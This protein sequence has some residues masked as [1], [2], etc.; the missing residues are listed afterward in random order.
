[1][2]PGPPLSWGFEEPAPWL[3]ASEEERR[4]GHLSSDLC[5]IRGEHFFVRGV[6]EIPLKDAHGLFLWNVWVSLS[7]ESFGRML[8]CFD[9]PDRAS[10]PACFGW[11]SNSIP[12]YP[13][14]L[15]LKTMVHTRA[16]GLRPAIELEPTDH[17]LA[18]E[19]RVG[20]G[21]DRVKEIAQQLF[22]RGV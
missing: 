7:K 16:P 18:V 19:Q 2:I 3:S 11:L 13:E 17:P 9:Q 21:M 15:S 20:I 12:V 10:G 8:D 22:H 1:M 5:V 6:I 14:T 4:E